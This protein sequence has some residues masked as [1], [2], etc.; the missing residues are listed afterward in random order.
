M[1]KVVLVSLDS[2]YKE[3]LDYYKDRWLG[4]FLDHSVTCS[5][6]KT[7]FP[8]LTYPAHTTMVTGCDPIR[9]GIGQNQPFQ[10][11]VEEKKRRWYWEEAHVQCETLF[12]AVARQGGQCASIL[13]PVTGKST[14]IRWNFPEVLALPGEN[15]VLKMLR[16]G[17]AAWV[18]HMEL[19]HG[20]KRQ[21]VQEPFL[22]D[23]AA[24]IAVDVIRSKQPDLTAVHLVDVDATRHRYG[25][26]GKEV[27]EAL[28]RMEMRVYDIWDAIQHT[29]GMEDAL[30]IL[31]TDH[32]QG[33]VHQPVML[34]QALQQAGLS[35]QVQ[36]N[37]MT[38]YLFTEE[39][40]KVQAWLENNGNKVGVDRV[41]T[42][43]Q[44]NQMGCVAS[45]SLAVEA[46]EGTVF[47][48]GLSQAKR[49]KATHGFGPGHPGENCLLAVRGAGILP[50]NLPPMP[51]RDIAPTIAGLMG[52]QL[53]EAQGKDDCRK[54]LQ[55]R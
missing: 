36:S 52:I 9:H 44:L 28:D 38:A 50:R 33:D 21:G 43:E 40:E 24:A 54:I 49:E 35:V 55:I 51:M 7:V 8:A 42:R 10:P 29:P 41:Y 22:S 3:D 11:G 34:G 47:A 30:M 46:A 27:N 31:V 48:D 20:K 37:G 32:G 12:Q 19:R 4:D 25:V 53:P 2:M 45:V 14:A 26:N 13:W 6:V 1:R 15:Q 18:A 16:Y 5:E 17:S 23:Y 39:G